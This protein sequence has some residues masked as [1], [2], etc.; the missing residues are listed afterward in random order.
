M[1]MQGFQ[2]SLEVSNY[3]MMDRSEEE[4]KELDRVHTLRGIEIADRQVSVYTYMYIHILYLI[5]WL[6]SG[7]Q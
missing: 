2:G 6:L 7:S 3:P 1:H 5:Y 4:Q